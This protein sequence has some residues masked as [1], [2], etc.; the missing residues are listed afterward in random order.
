M[1]IYLTQCILC[2]QF[3]L[4]INIIY[5]EKKPQDLKTIISSFI[6]TIF[7]PG[8]DC[9]NLILQTLG[10]IRPHRLIFTTFILL[11][12][13]IISS[14][15]VVVIQWLPCDQFEEVLHTK[16]RNTLKYF[17]WASAN[18]GIYGIKTF[19]CDLIVTSL[20]LLSQSLIVILP[21]IFIDKIMILQTVI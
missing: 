15:R 5:W 14:I 17:V 20:V 10:T 6:V 2:I 13:W 9:L 12:P 3:I 21:T 18:V 11:S 4:D 19:I 7:Q 16:S 1:Y 8:S